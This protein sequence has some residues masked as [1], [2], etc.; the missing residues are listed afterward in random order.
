V[1]GAIAR[2]NGRGRA[3]PA[4]ASGG[5]EADYRD[6]ARRLGLP[7]AP[8]VDLGPGALA[9]VDAVRRGV[10][11][12]SASPDGPAYLAPDESTL[13]KVGRWLAGYQNIRDR[14]VIATPWAIRGALIEAGGHLFVENA[15]ERLWRVYPDLSARRVMT[16][17]QLAAGV[18]V[19][20]AA[21][22]SLAVAPVPALIAINLIA[23]AFFFGVTVMRFIAAS[24]TARRSLDRDPPLAAGDDLPVYSLLVPLY[25]EAMLVDELIAVLDR[26]DWPRDR[27]DIKLIVEA[28]DAGTLAAVRRA[29]AGP[30][31]EVVVVPP[32]EPRTK[33]KALAFAHPFIR[34]DYVTV[35]DA[36]DRPHPGQLRE[37]FAAFERAGPELAC[38][39]SPLVIDNG[40]DGILAQLF[41]IEYA[42]LFDGL[43]PTLASF[44][45]PLPLGGTSNHFRRDALEACGG[46]DPYN[47]TED[48]DLG[49]RLARFGYRT[50]TLDLPTEEEAPA[51][52]G[53]WLKQRTRWFKGWMQTWLVHT[54]HPVRLC[55]ELGWRQ[56]LGFNLIGTGLILSAM[57]HPI[58]LA[59]V[60][61]VATDPLLL[62][63][64]GGLFA[65]VVVG[66]NLFNLAAGYLAMSALALHALRLR[67][68]AD[69]A[70]ALGLLP[71]YWLLMSVASYRALLQLI[72]RPHH[73]E[74]TPHRRGSEGARPLP[75]LES[76]H[77]G[78]AQQ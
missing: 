51:A 47:V 39:Q 59:T 35:Y 38:L 4:I 48:A 24:A 72:W 20:A 75:R 16:I 42:A 43:L 64:D 7:F 6:R 77:P 65:A 68:R 71:V 12:V 31:Y 1:R 13:P 74:K 17:G 25:Q 28:D 50:A 63:G 36:E 11:A 67:G 27:L 57:I 14:L 26:I 2:R 8:V 61:V 9:N 58:Y 49:I 55:R 34:G 37:A 73:W 76:R 32:A 70:H 45:M 15:V 30:P 60:V 33:P 23:A 22:V 54:R 3:G 52:L 66:I 5:G 53:A 41:A 40:R 19:V 62:W 21:A 44:G 18:M 10:F 56:F 29:V 78:L 46:W 69:K